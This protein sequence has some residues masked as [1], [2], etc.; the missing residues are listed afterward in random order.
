MS[1]GLLKVHV[2]KL[3]MFIGLLKMSI[4]LLK[5]HVDKLKVFID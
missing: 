2:D 1:I 4:G 5:V 3:K